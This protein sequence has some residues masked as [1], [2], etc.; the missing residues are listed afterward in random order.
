M[1]IKVEINDKGVYINDELIEGKD[2]LYSFEFENTLEPVIYTGIETNYIIVISTLIISLAG[3][4]TGIIVL[5]KKN[6]NKIN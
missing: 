2:S 1:I 6:K 3:I 5:R 4:I